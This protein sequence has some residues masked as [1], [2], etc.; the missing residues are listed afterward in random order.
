MKIKIVII[1]KVFFVSILLYG[2]GVLIYKKNLIPRIYYLI[3]GKK[4]V[5]DIV[6]EKENKID[7]IF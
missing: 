2:L 3:I 5:D 1:V 4:T 6:K 7:S